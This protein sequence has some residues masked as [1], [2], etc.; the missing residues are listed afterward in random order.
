L[1]LTREDARFF[2]C[3]REV[4]HAREILNRGSSAHRQIRTFE[5]AI[6]AGASREQALKAVVDF[7]VQET[8]A[9]L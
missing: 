6:A 4:N 9:D 8:V 2:D 7:L 3:E 1:K 5:K